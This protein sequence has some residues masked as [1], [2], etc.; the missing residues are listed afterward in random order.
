MKVRDLPQKQQTGHR[1]RAA[2]PF[3]GQTSITSCGPAQHGRQGTNNGADPGIDCRDALERGVDGGIECNIGGSNS[4]SCVVGLILQQGKPS[5][6]GRGSEDSSVCETEA[7]SGQR[8]QAGAGH[9]GVGADF[10]DLVEGVCT[11]GG[12]PGARGDCRQRAPVGGRG[13]GSRI[14][15]VVMAQGVARGGCEGDET[16]ETVLG[17]LEQV[18]G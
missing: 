18:A 14:V 8:T 3:A 12:E 9:E 7:A 4:G 6:A 11:G 2:L 1:P 13:S 15:G 17:E 5:G 10:V 16:G